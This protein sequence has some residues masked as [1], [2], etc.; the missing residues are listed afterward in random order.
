MARL[1]HAP[2]SLYLRI[3][4]HHHNQRRPGGMAVR[5][6]S[7]RYARDHGGITFTGTKVAVPPVR[8]EFEGMSA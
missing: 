5:Q 7:W 1:R 8:C 3:A 4:R 2:P 6:R